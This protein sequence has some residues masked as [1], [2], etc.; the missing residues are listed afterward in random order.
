MPAVVGPALPV[1]APPTAAAEAPIEVDVD[2]SDSTSAS[3]E[4]AEFE[5]MF[6]PA[7]R[8]ETTPKPL[9]TG[10]VGAEELYARFSAMRVASGHPGPAL[11]M[12]AFQRTLEAQR[13]ALETKNPGKQVE[14]DIE[15]RDGAPQL[16]PRMSPRKK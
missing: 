12:R 6:G 4:V 3:D 2:L 16:R 10:E 7:K 13:R 1:P 11:S 14:F 8:P 9:V 5:A 15:V